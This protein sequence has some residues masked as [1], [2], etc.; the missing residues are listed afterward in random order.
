VNQNIN[1]N[2]DAEDFFGISFVSDTVVFNFGAG[3]DV[4]LFT[5]D[6]AL[7]DMLED[8]ISAARVFLLN[9]PASL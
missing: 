8:A 7:L 9:Q 2:V 1:L 6:V 3:D 4:R 5:K